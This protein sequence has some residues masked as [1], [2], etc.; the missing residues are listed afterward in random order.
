MVAGGFHA[1]STFVR[2]P[3]LDPLRG[4]PAFSALLL[5]AEEGRRQSLEAFLA[6]GGER[7]L[8]AAG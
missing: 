2:D 8:G 6:A 1:H 4:L 3:W 7:L 5:R